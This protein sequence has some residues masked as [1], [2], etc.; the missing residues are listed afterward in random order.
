MAG[1]VCFMA[2]LSGFWTATPSVSFYIGKYLTFFAPCPAVC[3]FLVNRS[4]ILDRGFLVVL[5]N[6]NH[7]VRPSLL[8]LSHS[9]A[10]GLGI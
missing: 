5:I 8:I 7:I 2:A 10:L 9:E 3:S 6:L 4:I 1:L